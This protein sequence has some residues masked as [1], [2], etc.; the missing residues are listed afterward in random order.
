MQTIHS[1]KKGQKDKPKARTEI[2]PV[3]PD[4]EGKQISDSG[5]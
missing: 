2:P 3:F 1:K 4:G 5:L